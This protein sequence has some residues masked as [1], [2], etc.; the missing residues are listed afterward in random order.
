MFALIIFLVCLFT[1]LGTGVLAALSDIRGM[2][3][4]NVYS[5]IIIVA[6]FVAFAALSLLGQA[7][8][9]FGFE[10][11]LL[12]LIIVFGATVALFGLHVIGA[13][14]SKL[15]SAY[16][17]WV[18]VVPGLFAFLMYTALAGG[19]LALVALALKKWKPLKSPP[20]GSW[21]ARVQAGESKVPYGAAILAGAL[22]SFIKL[23]YL[24]AGVFS[25]FLGL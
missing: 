10:S 13:A 17:L 15:A 4:P 18:G 25:S 19:V 11:H 22:A 21:P 6:F 8:V 7:D 24:G 5:G 16:A 3:I 2:T 9:F 1:A 14:D 23:G 12:A 20:A